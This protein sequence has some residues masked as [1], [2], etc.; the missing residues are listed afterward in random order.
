MPGPRP[1]M[2]SGAW[3][4]RGLCSGRLN[5]TPWHHEGRRHRWQGRNLLA[6][7][8]VSLFAGIPDDGM[9]KRRHRRRK[10]TSMRE[11]R[12]GPWPRRGLVGVLLAA[13]LCFGTG[14]RA[15]TI[16]IACGS[17]GIEYKLCKE[18]AEAWGAKAGH[19]VQVVQTP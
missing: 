7:E 1:G 2:T 19:Q 18:G 12:R 17:V 5:L 4:E 9:A 3:M 10:E 16:A 13:A 14:A 6:D 15:E 11:D 8:R